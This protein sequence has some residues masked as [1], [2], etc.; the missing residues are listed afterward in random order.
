MQGEVVGQEE[1]RDSVPR[2]RVAQVLQVN[3]FLPDSGGA[4]NQLR[5]LG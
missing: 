4:R 3:R 1:V 5:G 2:H